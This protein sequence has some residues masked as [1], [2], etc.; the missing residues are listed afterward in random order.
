M[1][2]SN[3]Y[4]HRTHIVNY[5]EHFPIQIEVAI[6]SL[7]LLLWN[8]FFFNFITHTKNSFQNNVNVV[9]H[10]NWEQCA[11]FWL[12]SIYRMQRQPPQT[13]GSD[14]LANPSHFMLF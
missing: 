14:L 5:T 6:H 3:A 4:T 9:F 12:L 2:E 1:I 11:I 8:Q 7:L 10:R 13:T